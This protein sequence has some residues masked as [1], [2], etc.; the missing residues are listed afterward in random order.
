M[1]LS[2]NRV[3][4]LVADGG[5]AGSSA[6]RG[7]RSAGSRV[8]FQHAR[9]IDTKITGARGR[10]PAGGDRRGAENEIGRRSGGTGTSGET[11]AA[12]LTGR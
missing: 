6:V 10:N 4:G 11:E 9:L 3:Y 5:E 7:D 8:R 12:L 2:L 1:G